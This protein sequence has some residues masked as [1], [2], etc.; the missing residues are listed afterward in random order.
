M[1]TDRIVVEKDGQR[2]ARLAYE[3]LI[4]LI[5]SGQIKGGETIQER[6]LADR[7]GVSRS[8]IR[9]ALIL[10]EGEGI[11]TRQSG[12]LLQ[13]KQFTVT[14][15]V[16]SL[17]IR[18]LLEPEAARQA[19]GRIPPAT[20][21]DLRTK[22]QALRDFADR[23]QGLEP[24]DGDH[25]RI[26]DDLHNTILDHCGNALMADIVRDVRRKT[27]MFDLRR[28]PERFVQTCNEHEHLLDTLERSDGDAA[29]AAMTAHLDAVFQSIVTRIGE[30][31]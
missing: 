28:L 21:A 3:R 9:E 16:Q 17:Q 13:V 26:D 2:L 30:L 29:A 6:R 7:L 23:P 1:T 15:Y 8:P 18:R 24:E 22:L 14:D 27:R 25:R 31:Y 12:G 20:L 19:V 10:L 4:D 5:L 11:L